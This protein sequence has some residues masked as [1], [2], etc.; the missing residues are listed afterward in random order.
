[1]YFWGIYRENKIWDFTRN[2]LPQSSGNFHPEADPELRK[3]PDP[4]PE[5]K[6]HWSGEKLGAFRM[7]EGGRTQ[8]LFLLSNPQKCFESPKFGLNFGPFE[9]NFLNFTTKSRHGVV[10]RF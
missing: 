2:V 3:A 9:L 10:R 1:M 7:T 4:D 8:I 5:L 6:S